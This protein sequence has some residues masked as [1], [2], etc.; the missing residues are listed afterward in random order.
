MR[1]AAASSGSQDR[2]AG[3]GA[4]RGRR[5]RG[6][7][8][9]GTKKLLFSVSAHNPELFMVFVILALLAQFEVL[10]L[11]GPAQATTVAVN[12]FCSNQS[13]WPRALERRLFVAAERQRYEVRDSTLNGICAR[14]T[15]SFVGVAR[16]LPA[17][18]P[19]APCEWTVV[20][21]DCSLP[22]AELA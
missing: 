14:G 21:A 8:Q 7:R 17:P 1:M 11:T 16:R 15:I 2:G 12:L 6:L 3:R 5:G 13:F 18:D 19:A 20:G 9:I 4:G 10:Q 22:A